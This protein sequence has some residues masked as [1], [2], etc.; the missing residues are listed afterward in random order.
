V[1]EVRLDVL[2]LTYTVV[3]IKIG[4]PF[5]TLNGAK[6]EAMHLAEME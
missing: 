4:E 1:W 2:G 3:F 6:K 5:R